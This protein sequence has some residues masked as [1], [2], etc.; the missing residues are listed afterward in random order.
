MKKLL[1][2]L[3][4]LPAFVFSQ[5][6]AGYYDSAEGLS[7]TALKSALHNI[8]DNHDVQSYSDLH[9]HFENTD[10]KPNGKVWD[11]YS[12]VPGGTPPYEYSFVSG[13]Q[14]G[15]YNSEADCYNREHSWPK[16]WFGGEVSPMYSDLF[17]LYPTDGYVNGKRSSF[18][19]GEVGSATWTSMNGSKLGTCNFPGYNGTVFEPI[20]EYKGDFARAYFYMTVRYLGEDSGWPGSDMTTGAQLKPWAL[21]LMRKWDFE[22]PVSTKEIDRNN[23]VYNIQGNR[24]PFIDNPNW[25]DSIYGAYLY[26]EN[27]INHTP[28]SYQ[29]NK[30]KLSLEFS[31]K[32]LQYQIVSLTGFVLLSGISNEKENIEVEIKN[33][34]VF[35]LKV[36]NNNETWSEKLFVIF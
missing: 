9:N 28:Y 4:L 15:S 24:N 11:M 26:I 8:I 13:D 25:V 20:D 21:E 23:E 16:S 35:L 6:P 2:L 22:D 14:C 30:S 5:I 36:W 3:L 10:K 27:I 7:G 32:D 17:I 29:I 34:G 18:P 12:D 33:S 1:F 19:Y 31:K